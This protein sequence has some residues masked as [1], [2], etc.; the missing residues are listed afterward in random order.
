MKY[1]F[2]LFLN[3]DFEKSLEVVQKGL[4]KNGRHA[5]FNRL[6]M[7]NYTDLKRYDEPKKRQMIFQC[8]GQCRLLLFGLPV[9]RCFAE[10]FEEV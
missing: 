10:C 8:L 2:A 9:L 4:Q 6:A 5:A 3:H 1:A 7:Y